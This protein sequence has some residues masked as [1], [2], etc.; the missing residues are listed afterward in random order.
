[1]ITIDLKVGDTILTGKWRN[2]KVVIKTIGTD[3]HGSPTVNG[4]SILNIRIPKLYVKENKMKQMKLKNLLKEAY[5]DQGIID[6]VVEIAAKYSSS[7]E[8][9]DERD[10]E[11]IDIDYLI[12]SIQSTNFIPKNKWAKFVKE[13]QL[14][15]PKGMKKHWGK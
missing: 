3:E 1:M 12:D 14:Y 4:K 9:W 6:D 15:L 11:F 10:L 2:K 7:K 13:V 8:I 5:L